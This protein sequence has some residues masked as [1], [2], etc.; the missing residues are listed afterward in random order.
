METNKTVVKVLVLADSR[1]R[2]LEEL[3]NVN[4]SSIKFRMEVLPA[5]SISALAR[6][7]HRILENSKHPEWW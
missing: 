3:M 7:M 5:T 4:N 1:G 2:D 6:R